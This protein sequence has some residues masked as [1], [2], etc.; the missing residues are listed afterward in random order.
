M[1]DPRVRAMLKRYRHKKLSYLLFNQK[2]YELPNRT[3]RTIGIIYHIFKLNNFRD[4][5]SI[6]Q[7]KACLDM[8][9]NELKL[10]TSIC[11]NGKN[12][13]LTINKTEEKH[14]GRYRLGLNSIFVPITSP[15]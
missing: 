13:P 9:S 10:S 2:N 11:W 15:F 5:Q 3:I 7:D 6:Y 8:T 1:I 12:Q 14:T 4:V